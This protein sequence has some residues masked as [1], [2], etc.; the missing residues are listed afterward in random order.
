[1]YGDFEDGKV[2]GWIIGD[3]GGYGR[4]RGWRMI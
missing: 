3:N 2:G 4:G 1:M